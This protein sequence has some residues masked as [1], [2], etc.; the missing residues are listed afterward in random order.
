MENL[1]S[2]PREPNLHNEYTCSFNSSHIED[3]SKQ[4]IQTAKLQPLQACELREVCS[5]AYHSNLGQ[6]EYW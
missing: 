5:L 1:A 6:R 2:T 4:T 3:V